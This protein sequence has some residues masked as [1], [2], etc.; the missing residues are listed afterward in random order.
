M[1]HKLLQGKKLL[2]RAGLPILFLN[3]VLLQGAPDAKA[4]ASSVGATDG[5]ISGTVLS[6]LDERPV[7]QAA[8]SVR[9]HSLGV[10]RS[11][12]TDYDGRFEVRG[13]SPGTY[14]VEVEQPGYESLQTKAQFE[15]SPVK[16][17]LH[18]MASKISQ[19]FRNNNMVSVQ[20]LKVPDKARNEYRKG[21]E[22]M[23]KNDAAGS[24]GHFAKA[25]Q[26]YPGYFEAFY[27]MGAVETKLG[28]LT[29]AREAFQTAIDLSGGKYAWAEFGF[30][31]VLYLQGKTDEAEA[32]LRR[33]L[34]VD[35]NSPDG[36][37]ILGMTLLR[38]NRL[39]EAEKCARQALLHKPSF[40]QAYLVLADV[41][42]HR[43]EFRAQLQNLDAY[44][45]LEPNG[46]AS[47]LVHHARE[48]ALRMVGEP[49]P[50]E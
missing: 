39:E 18:L 16:L 8:V 2:L 4:Q 20:E 10:F 23:G 6:K 40:S 38:L 28:R 31:Y 7:E 5:V 25:T 29:E 48:V 46:A 35:E 26:A 47:D 14:E 27:H 49:K 41:Y 45:Q 17:V 34:E 44:L 12:L 43:R 15:G 36:Y 50:Q 42:A 13:L 19:P 21:L 22:C 32:V 9:S 11:I 3:F 37:T 33:G 1:L 24:L 30:G